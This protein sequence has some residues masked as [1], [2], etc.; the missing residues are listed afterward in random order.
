MFSY[1]TAAVNLE[2]DYSE[3]LYLCSKNILTFKTK[4]NAFIQLSVMTKHGFVLTGTF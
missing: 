3:I 2:N 4:N 1:E